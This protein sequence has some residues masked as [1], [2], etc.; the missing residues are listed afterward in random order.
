MA[1]II[2]AYSIPRRTT[3]EKV[4]TPKAIVNS[5][6]NSN[7]GICEVIFYVSSPESLYRGLRQY[8]KR[9]EIKEIK[10]H[11]RN[12]HIYMRKIHG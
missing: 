1:M 10:V 8:I 4:E 11:I 3:N 12:S 7:E 2:S 9:K 5:F 6:L